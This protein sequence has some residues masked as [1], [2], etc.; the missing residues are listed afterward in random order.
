[1]EFYFLSLVDPVTCLN[2]SR[3]LPGPERLMM[4][5]GGAFTYKYYHQVPQIFNYE[6]QVP[7]IFNYEHWFPQIFQYEHW[8]PQILA[9]ASTLS[10]FG[11]K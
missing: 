11:E 7:Q 3:W 1:M 6:R 2:C 4:L 9:P 5:F 10:V 8:F